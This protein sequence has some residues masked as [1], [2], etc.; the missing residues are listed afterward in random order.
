MLVTYTCL[1]LQ[2]SRVFDFGRDATRI[3][4]ADQDRM[5]RGVYGRDDSGTHVRGRSER[6]RVTGKGS[7]D[8]LC[9][10]RAFAIDCQGQI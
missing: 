6:N 2:V 9:L 10:L 3:R 1:S 7:L 4:M 8:T 5:R